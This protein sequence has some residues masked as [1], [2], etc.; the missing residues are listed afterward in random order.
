MNVKLLHY[1]DSNLII[2]NRINL[3]PKGSAS[4]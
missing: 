1:S 2:I 3:N 4:P